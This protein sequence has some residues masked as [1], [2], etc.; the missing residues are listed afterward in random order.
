[1]HASKTTFSWWNNLATCYEF[2]LKGNMNVFDGFAEFLVCSQN[3][4]LK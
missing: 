2:N 1:M 3:I 4:K